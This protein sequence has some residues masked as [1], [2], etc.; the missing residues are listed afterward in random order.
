MKEAMFAEMQ[1]TE[2]VYPAYNEMSPEVFASHLD[3]A[4]AVPMVAAILLQVLSYPEHQLVVRRD[5]VAI[6][7]KEGDTPPESV[8]PQKTNPTAALALFEVLG[9]SIKKGEAV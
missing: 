9:A 6:R 2:I 8:P 7:C 1:D 5:G 3:V 4:L